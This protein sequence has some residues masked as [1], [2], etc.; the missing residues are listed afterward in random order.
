MK[1]TPSSVN[2]SYIEFERFYPFSWDEL[3]FTFNEI[4]RDLL[5]LIKTFD[6]KAADVVFSFH[7]VAPNNPMV[8]D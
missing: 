3:I 4:S 1:S 7:S 6:N 2:S 5:N 8:T